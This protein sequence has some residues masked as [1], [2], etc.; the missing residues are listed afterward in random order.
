MYKQYYKNKLL[1]I[2]KASVAGSIL[3]SLPSTILLDKIPI[4]GSGYMDLGPYTI[5]NL[6]FVPGLGMATNTISGIAGALSDSKDFKQV[7]KDNKNTA[8]EFLPGV[9]SFKLSKQRRVVENKLKNKNNK[10]NKTLSEELGSYTSGALATL[11]GALIAG[12]RASKGDRRALSYLGGSAG[13]VASGSASLLGGLITNFTKGRD[14]KDLKK[15]YNNNSTLYNY[16]IP[17]VAE[18]NRW[19]NL[20]AVD[21][22]IEASK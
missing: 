2:K 3:R 21:R 12:A 22:L 9:A 6:G 17:G 15:Y 19:K 18:Y 16:L 14:K 5:P 11:I 4:S 8:S 1:N 10:S 13:L 20:M 7:L